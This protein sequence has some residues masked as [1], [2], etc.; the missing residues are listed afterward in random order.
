MTPSDTSEN[1]AAAGVHLAPP[2]ALYH[3]DAYQREF[4]ATVTAADAAGVILDRTVFFPGGGGQP[5]DRGVLFWEGSEHP[6]VEMMK[7]GEDAV[8]R[9]PPPWPAPGTAVRGQLDWEHRHA[10]MRTHTALHILCG[11]IWRDFGAQVTGSNMKPLSAR[12]DFELE[13]MPADLPRTIEERVAAE[14]A[15]DREIRVSFMPR[16]EALAIPDLIRTKVNL[17]P[18][19][20][21]VIRIIDIVGLDCQADGGTH[22]RS[23]REVGRVR[24]VKHENKGRINKRLYLEV[25]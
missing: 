20:I 9:T 22:V 1:R 6:V 4:E 21:A 8:H 10:L 13:G 19:A 14:I 18:D 24:I 12:M 16:A 2:A 3:I 25:G 5:A 17:L 15:A 11:I 7:R 23:T